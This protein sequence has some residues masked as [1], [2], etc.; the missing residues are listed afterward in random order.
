MNEDRTLK[1]W[2]SWSDSF[3]E[4]LDHPRFRAYCN[5]ETNITTLYDMMD[6]LYKIELDMNK[7][8]GDSRATT[9]AKA[10]A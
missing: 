8:V 7:S 1:D 4:I 2:Q 3:D 5:N 10:K 6:M 9:D